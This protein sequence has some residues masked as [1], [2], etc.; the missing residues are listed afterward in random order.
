MQGKAAIREG[1][2]WGLGM[3]VQPGF[4]VRH[5]WLQERN[6]AVEV[7]THHIFPNNVAL[8]FPQVFVFETNDTQI[9][10]LQ[11]YEPYPPPMSPV[12]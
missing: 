11:A 5:A 7:D 2:T 10:R 6:G 12:Q 3:I 8:Q 1:L 9:T 4:R